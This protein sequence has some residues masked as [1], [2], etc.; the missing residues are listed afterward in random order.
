MRSCG[1][2]GSGITLVSHATLALAML[3]SGA[4]SAQ[5]TQAASPV[6]SAQA[7]DVE[8]TDIVVTPVIRK[9]H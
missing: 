2:T 8:I 5:T 6:N 4:V 1:A 7:G 9:R 3:W